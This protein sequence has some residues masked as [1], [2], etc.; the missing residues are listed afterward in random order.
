MD[1]KKLNSTESIPKEF[2]DK[3]N[4][5]YREI[6]KDENWD[7]VKDS[8]G[9]YVYEVNTKSVKNAIK[10][11][12]ERFALHGVDI[13]E[14]NFDDYLVE[15]VKLDKIPKGALTVI[16]LN[17][18]DSYG[19]SGYFYVFDKR[20]SSGR[21]NPLWE[22]GTGKMYHSGK[23]KRVDVGRIPDYQFLE[24]AKNVWVIPEE[25]IT[26]D[27]SKV[28]TDRRNMKSG[29]V[30]RYK[31]LPGYRY[32]ENRTLDK[33]GYIIDPSEISKRLKEFKNKNE[34]NKFG[35]YLGRAENEIKLIVDEYNSMA[36]TI[37]E[38]A[39]KQ[40][41]KGKLTLDLKPL[42][43]VNSRLNS[44]I[45][46][47]TRSAKSADSSNDSYTYGYDHYLK[48]L[49]EIKT[50]YTWGDL[51]RVYSRALDEQAEDSATEGLGCKYNRTLQATE[52]YFV[53]SNIVS[54]FE[55]EE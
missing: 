45:D 17:S 53:D 29:R 20:R 18:A 54:A 3:A 22:A 27:V 41:S 32:N 24:A 28:R 31:E 43:E 9:N 44:A 51:T 48:R 47:L 5:A 10:G 33:S 50:S 23:G 12:A 21:E 34:L 1:D 42:S 16:Q 15:G 26:R 7:Y 8:K 38:V 2:I 11:F 36:S 4:T 40:L 52:S 46:D 14:I 39:T 6:K 13:N 55:S 35:G 25:A 49:G 30:V 37:L 19:P